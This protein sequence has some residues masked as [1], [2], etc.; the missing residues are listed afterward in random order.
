MESSKLLSQTGIPQVLLALQNSPKVCWS[1][2]PT[3]AEK[4]AL[5]HPQ[6]LPASTHL[7]HRTSPFSLSSQNKD[8]RY[9]ENSQVLCEAL[10]SL[11]Q[12]NSGE[13]PHFTTLFI[14][15]KSQA[16]A[17]VHLSFIFCC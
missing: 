13:L 2:A 10:T 11:L 15:L 16:E 5:L 12:I 1:G 6:P 8:Q 14:T 17:T 9:C 7:E 4:D 3:V